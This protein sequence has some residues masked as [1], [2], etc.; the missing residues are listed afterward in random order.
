MPRDN[1]DDRRRPRRVY[2]VGAEPDARFSLANERTYLAWIRTSLALMA[3][4]VALDVFD[5]G[6]NTTPAR[7]A[8]VLLIGCSAVLPLHAWWAWG[9]VESSLRRNRPLPSPRVGAPLAILLAVAAALVVWSV[10]S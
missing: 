9:A 3:A 8:S 10:F 2:S 7:I 5:V 6:G 4:G 1:V